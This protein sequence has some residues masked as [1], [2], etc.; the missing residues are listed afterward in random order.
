[1]NKI[2]KTLLTWLPS[3]IITLFFIPNALDK[4]LNS[5]QTEKIVANSA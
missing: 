5:N 3:I 4:I 2:L 1:M